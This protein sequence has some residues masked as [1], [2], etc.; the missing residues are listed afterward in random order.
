[1]AVLATRL[2]CFLCFTQP[3]PAIRLCIPSM[4]IS[5]CGTR[6]GRD[7]CWDLSSGLDVS[8]LDADFDLLVSSLVSLPFGSLAYDHYVAFITSSYSNRH[9]ALL[10]TSDQHIKLRWFL[11]TTLPRTRLHCHCLRLFLFTLVGVNAM[12]SFD[13]SSWL[14]HFLEACR[15][16]YVVVPV[17]LV[18]SAGIWSAALASSALK[19]SDRWLQHLERTL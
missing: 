1:V 16:K 9:H 5:G 10:D 2:P 15:N 12:F 14:S 18:C 7:H 3:L 6:V 11:G 13:V 17:F 19:E 8:G 4:P